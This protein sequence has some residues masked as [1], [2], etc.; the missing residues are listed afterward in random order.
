MSNW[1][2]L[3]KV[4]YKRTYARQLTD[5]TTEEW[6]QT[7]ARCVNGAQKIGAKYTPD[8][9]Q[10]LYDYIF[11]LKCN[12]AGR[13]LWQLGTSTVDRFGANSL[14]NCWFTAMRKPGDFSFLFENLMLGG[15]VG[16]SIRREDVHE[17]PKIKVGV[18][19]THQNTNDADFIV[20][21]SR[22][23]WVKLLENVFINIIKFINLKYLVDF[24]F[25]ELNQETNNFKSLVEK[26]QLPDSF[27]GRDSWKKI[28]KYSGSQF[29]NSDWSFI[30]KY[31]VLINFNIYLIKH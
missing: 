16:Y 11:N 25:L 31:L 22:E 21:D 28:I 9:A 17:L 3:A 6:W 10:L 24:N 15:G 29:G 8:E 12:F 30:V 19:V 7:V 4:V 14:L 20:S 2:N 26:N 13:M 18:N 23:G 27:N 1:S 5:G